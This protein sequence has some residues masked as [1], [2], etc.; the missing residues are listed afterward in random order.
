MTVIKILWSQ[1]FAR[2]DYFDAKKHGFSASSYLSAGLELQ[3]W[4]PIS[5][6]ACELQTPSGLEQRGQEG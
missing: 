1:Y 4:A 5:E 2:S 3:Q 6:A